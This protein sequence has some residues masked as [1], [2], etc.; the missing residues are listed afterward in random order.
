MKKGYIIHALKTFAKTIV[1]GVIIAFIVNVIMI[2]TPELLKYFG[3]I[4][5]FDLLQLQIPLWIV[6]TFTVFMISTVYIAVLHSYSSIKEIKP[7][8]GVIRRK[9]KYNVIE[10]KMKFFG[11]DWHVF[12]GRVT[13]FTDSYGF[14]KSGPLCPKCGYEMDVVVKKSWF[15]KEKYW[16]CVPCQK[17]YKYPKG[18]SD[19]EKVVIKCVEAYF[20]SNSLS[21]PS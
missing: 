2:V 16:K 7:I 21:I 15:R 20:R 11:V 13:P 14:V 12:Y 10:G 18:I 8:L 17:L 3:I 4:S 6:L 5:P 19:P 9:P 1:K